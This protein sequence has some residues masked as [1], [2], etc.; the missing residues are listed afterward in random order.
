MGRVSRGCDLG[1]ALHGLAVVLAVAGLQACAGDTPTAPANRVGASRTRD[2]SERQLLVQQVRAL[3][4]KRGIIPLPPA[5]VVRP[6]LVRLGREL[7]FDKILSGNRDIACMTCHLP[8]FATGDGRS[9]PIGT[10]GSR[11][12]PARR[13]GSGL[14]IPRNAPPLFNLH[15]LPALFWD[16]RVSLD[17]TGT[18][19]TPAGA[20][21]TPAMT[22]VFEFGAVSAQGLFPVLNRLEMRGASGNELAQLPDS[23]D[24]AIWRAAMRRLGRIRRYRE[25]F[26]EAYPG[27]PFDSLNFAHATNAIAGFLI[28]SFNFDQSPW[29]R[30]LGGDND[31]LSSGQLVGAQNFLSLKCSICHNGSTFSDNQFHDV[32][33]AQFGPGEG[34]LPNVRDDFGR[35]NVTANPG[36]IYRFRTTPLRNVEL[37]GPYGHAGQFKA[38][39]DF[40]AHYSQSDVKLLTYDPRQIDPILFGTLID[41]TNAVLAARDTLLAG[42]VIPDSTIDRLTTYMTALTDPRARDLRHL[43]PARVPSGLPVDP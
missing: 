25:L 21:L 31:A 32:A 43:T 17:A 7:A 36:D 41:N 26:R 42:V 2:Q 8:E 27:V 11:L 28:S 35:F 33:L 18:F 34:V 37:T 16:G 3:A 1:S 5:P 9:M 29:D 4:A 40:V 14:I 12:G 15:A 39:R 19:H 22:R 6:S 30:F 13:L 23:D 20:Q 24:G 38:L 10:G